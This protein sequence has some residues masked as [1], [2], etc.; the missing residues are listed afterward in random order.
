M[1]LK[2]WSKELLMIKPDPTPYLLAARV[3]QLVRL[4]PES[5]EAFLYTTTPQVLDNTLSGEHG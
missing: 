1:A 5:G 4:L 3:P 2:I